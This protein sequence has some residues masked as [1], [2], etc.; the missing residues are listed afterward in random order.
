LTLINSRPEDLQDRYTATRLQ[1][2]PIST[3]LHNNDADD[4][5]RAAEQ[6][7]RQLLDC[8]HKYPGFRGELEFDW[9]VAFLGQSV[10]RKADVSLELCCERGP[11]SRSA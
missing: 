6:D 1:R 11:A 8:S 10:T 7:D 2:L 4:V 3:E 9:T 5:I